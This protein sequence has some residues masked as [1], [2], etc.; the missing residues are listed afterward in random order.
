MGYPGNFV[1]DDSHGDDPSCPN[2]KPQQYYDAEE[3]EFC[4][5][6]GESIEIC[7]GE[8]V[9]GEVVCAECYEYNGKEECEIMIKKLKR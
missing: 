9:A 6:C 1:A 8:E 7:G 5:L 3:P 4:C 2:W